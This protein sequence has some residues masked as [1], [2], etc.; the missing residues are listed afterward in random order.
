MSSVHIQTAIK[1]RPFI[2]REKKDKLEPSWLVQDNS[3][4]QIDS[5]KNFIGDPY[6]F[7]HIF[8]DT[9][10]NKHVYDAVVKPLV[11]SCFEGINSTIFAYGQTSSGKTHTMLGSKKFPGIISFAVQDIFAFINQSC[12]TKF[13][14]RCSY[15]EI[16][17]E[18]INDLLD[19][20]ATDIKIR[21]GLEGVYVVVKEEV[22]REPEDLFNLMNKGMKTRKIGCTDMNERS[23]RSH[24]IFKLIIQSQDLHS[25]GS[26]VESALNLVDLAGSERVG[27]MNMER[28]RQVEGVSINKSLTTLGLVIRKL[29]ENDSFINY[30]DSKLTRLLQH[31]LGGNSKTL[32]IANITTAALEET[33][34]TLEF[35]QRAKYVKNQPIRNEKVTDKDQLKQYEHL[36]ED[37]KVQIEKLRTE[38]LERERTI[39]ALEGKIFNIELFSTKTVER[40]I[41]PPNRRHTLAFRP[42]KKLFRPEESDEVKDEIFISP[43]KSELFFPAEDKENIYFQEECCFSPPYKLARPSLPRTPG[44]PYSTLKQEKQL[45][46]ESLEGL[47]SFTNHENQYGN[48]L[49]DLKE[50]VDKLRLENFELKAKFNNIK[51]E[52]T[53]DVYEKLLLLKSILEVKPLQDT[54]RNSLNTIFE[55][56]P[57]LFDGDIDSSITSSPIK[58]DDNEV[59]STNQICA[60][61]IEE[62]KDLKWQL[63]EKERI[64]R[65]LKN[66]F[67]SEK[68]NID[69][70]FSQLNQLNEDLLKE[71][72]NIKGENEKL[73]TKIAQDK[74]IKEC[75]L[76]ILNGKIKKLTDYKEEMHKKLSEYQKSENSEDS[77]EI[78]KEEP[79]KEICLIKNEID[80]LKKSNEYL[81]EENKSLT[82]QIKQL[83][84]ELDDAMFSLSGEQKELEKVSQEL[85]EKCQ[86]SKSMEKKYF[87]QYKKLSEELL[88]KDELL[89]HMIEDAKQIQLT[90]EQFEEELEQ[91]SQRIAALE[92][93]VFEQE[94]L[95][96]QNQERL[97]KLD[98]LF[99]NICKKDETIETLQKTVSEQ[100]TQNEVDHSERRETA[101]LLEKL[102]SEKKQLEIQNQEHLMKLKELCEGIREKEETIETLQKNVSEQKIQN[103]VDH[104]ERR[105]AVIV[106]EKLV[107][108]KKQLETQNQEHLMKLKELCEGI[109]EKEETIETLQK[110]VSELKAQNQ[111]TIMCNRKQDKE[112]ENYQ[113]EMKTA[114]KQLETASL[115]HKQLEEKS[116]HIAILEKKLSEVEARNQTTLLEMK[117]TIET[118]QKKIEDIKQHE[119]QEKKLN[120]LE[121]QNKTDLLSKE[122]TIKTLIK[123]IEDMKQD[124]EIEKCQQELVLATEKSEKLSL[125]LKNLSDLESQNK[126]QLL[127][128]EE[129]IQMLQNKIDMNEECKQELVAATEKFETLSAKFEENCKQLEEKSEDVTELEKKLL[130]LK[131]KYKIQLV[132]KDETIKTLQ[133]KLEDM[134][135][136]E[137]YKQKL[138]LATE[139]FETLSAKFEENCE[140]LKEKSED[141]T[142][143]EKKLLELKIQLV[144]KDDTIKTLQNK[145]ENMTPNEEYK[146]KLAAATEKF[147]TLSVKFEENCKHLKET[148][149]D[150]TELEKKL[151]ELEIQLVEKDETI[152]TLQNKLE[153][154][155]SNEEY[156]Q[157]LAA[158]TE[159]F[160]TLSAKFKENCK[161]LKE[162]SEDITELE[163]KL[164]KMK[165]KYKI[166]LAEKDETIKTLQNK[167]KDMT[168]NVEYKEELALATEKFERLSSK[169]EENCKQLEGKSEEIIE[170]EK[171][172]LKLESKY[173]IQ[174]VE[175]DETI[176][177]L[178]NKLENM[179]PNQEYKQELAAATEKFETL[180]SKLQENCKQLKEK[181]EDVEELK[182]NLSQLESRS[183]SELLEK[184]ETIKT[185][186]RKKEDMEQNGEIKACQQELASTIK[187][188]Q[189]LSSQL[190]ENNEQ[191]KEKSENVA[192]LEKNL[193]ELKSQT[194]TE[195]LKKEETIKTLQTKIE[196]MKLVEDPSINK[197]V[198]N[199]KLELK[200][201]KEQ[202]ENL[203]KELKVKSEKIEEKSQLM[204][205][206]KAQHTKKVNNLLTDL[207]KK[208]DTIDTLH[209]KIENM[210]QNVNTKDI[211]LL[212]SQ[213][214]DYKNRLKEKT[215]LF[216]LAS[217]E[218][219]R[220]EKIVLEKS[221][222]VEKLQK[223]LEKYHLNQLKHYE[224][225]E[226]KNTT[227]LSIEKDKT[228]QIEELE[229]LKT[230]YTDK[231]AQFE[232]ITYENA[233]LKKQLS[234]LKENLLNKS[235]EI[236][237]L[238]EQINK[239]SQNETTINSY[240]IFGNDSTHQ[241]DE[242]K[243]IKKELNEKIYEN[244]KLH[245]DKRK[246]QHMVHELNQ[247]KFEKKRQLKE[248][249]DK[250]NSLELQMAKANKDLF[251]KEQDLAKEKSTVRQLQNKLKPETEKPLRHSTEAKV[252]PKELRK[253]RRHSLL[254]QRR[255]IATLDDD[256]SDSECINC[257]SI[258]KK[259]AEMSREIDKLKDDNQY[260]DKE[261]ED[262]LKEVDFLKEER[263]KLIFTL[264]EKEILTETLKE[265]LEGVPMHKRVDQETQATCDYHSKYNILLKTAL[266]RREEN[267][268]LRKKLNLPEDCPVLPKDI[269]LMATNR[270]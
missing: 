265:R 211:K 90:K 137:E 118:L 138:T 184:E 186:L 150:V 223:E 4:V 85:E 218:S 60:A 213:L 151:L 231:L 143:L 63:S 195:L 263:L 244:T 34:S 203:S 61:I 130:E 30:R 56:E 214:L 162:K 245:E 6:S 148:S 112:I 153:D 163:K 155:T 154:M 207:G 117:E 91:K 51:T 53:Q 36:C 31:S 14:L 220:F 132:E 237:K 107:S 48:E 76:E 82:E 136:N 102:V 209:K 183:K 172:L 216:E 219:D 224:K 29:S 52:D 177:T 266:H 139:K 175:K 159:K 232:K 109:R 134:T 267:N 40:K 77:L 110:T 62:N 133:N 123:R 164:L 80:E 15:L 221:E 20:N 119:K 229:A 165:S 104:N 46:E 235:V 268:Y 228:K 242:I 253:I 269:D 198:D 174:L 101:I 246:L 99:K 258:R 254:E 127:E 7:D 262:M 75:E 8:D 1:V 145:L 251:V 113:M 169:F 71:L 215:K 173:K 18:K 33:K 68:L 234:K 79:E 181:S 189:K 19:T 197:E 45:I 131:S 190:H 116:E 199:Y 236:E 26:Y 97:V 24:T 83:K 37:Y 72:D 217:L 239:F 187:K 129:T 161:Q 185:L 188:M 42:E 135:P 241:L 249:K 250:Y 67:H 27:Q 25:E 111:E 152:K 230:T 128:K 28:E 17:N 57:D 65:G 222:M 182:K 2:D 167:L 264:D 201:L 41:K 168:L 69:A 54:R 261:N 81:L 125:E 78:K 191:L 12:S 114:S 10:S 240:Q 212:K 49:D 141:V 270:Q 105:E 92:K 142:E 84:S 147:E 196:D 149:E 252:S 55:E 50:L 22:V 180:S 58:A 122:E 227:P 88:K 126:I 204:A 59:S 121:A 21:E 38:K 39:N 233:D 73:K 44:T 5:S 86:N 205:H 260:L 247:S 238:S 178:Q 13:L 202:F 210:Q 179:T 70:A 100:K 208:E 140:Q 11:M 206:L 170:L 257:A 144:E 47:R 192:K 226:S 106:L 87:D 176:K 9:Q 158:A 23:S 43:A 98:E 166:Q 259:C 103:E 32:I 160:E 248:L 66:D 146:Q 124:E 94:Q 200:T 96:T 74:D 95:E 35:A 225:T 108:E 64:I 115:E 93:L 156:K 3:I 16:Y 120:D 194:K 243:H 171:K 193:S 255:G 89:Q 157:E 256:S